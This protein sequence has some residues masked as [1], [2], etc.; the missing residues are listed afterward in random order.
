MIKEKL[1]LHLIWYPGFIRFFPYSTF[2][3][4]KGTGSQMSM[5][6][7]MLSSISKYAGQSS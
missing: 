7:S 6:P 5:S 4:V 3:F 2:F 1:F